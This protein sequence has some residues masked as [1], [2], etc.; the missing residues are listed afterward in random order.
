MLQYDWSV[1]FL[2]SFAQ[3]QFVLEVMVICVYWMKSHRA[4]M[5]MMTEFSNF[6][7]NYLGEPFKY[8]KMAAVM[9]KAYLEK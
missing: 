8:I 3:G 9:T 2:C 6:H 4:L 5:M 1:M 7:V